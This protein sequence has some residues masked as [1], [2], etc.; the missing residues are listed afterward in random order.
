MN[1]PATT[2]LRCPACARPAHYI[3]EIDRFVHTDGW[4]NDDCWLACTQGKG[5]QRIASLNDKI[6][7]RTPRRRRDGDDPAA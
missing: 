7:A 1:H 2:G 6:L 3:R 4:L 5:N